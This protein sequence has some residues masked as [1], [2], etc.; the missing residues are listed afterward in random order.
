M[1]SGF[2][3]DGKFYIELRSRTRAVGNMREESDRR[4]RDL[5]EQYGGNFLLGFSGGLDSQSVLHSFITQGIPLE[6]AFLHCPGHN[7]HELEQVR[8]L[9]GKYGIKTGVVIIDPEAAK[10]E[11]M[12]LSEELDV[13]T[14]NNILQMLFL[15]RLPAD[16]NFIQMVHDPF[17]YVY[18]NYEKFSYIQGYYLPEI[19]R[20]RAFASLARSGA[21]IF[22]GNTEEF[23]LSIIGDPIFRAALASAKYFDGNGLGHPQKYLRTVDRWDYYIK[24]LIYGRYWGR[25]LTYFPKWAGNE[26]LDF[27]N[28][29]H[30]FRQR[31]V[32]IPYGEL[33]AFL[34]KPGGETRRFYE[35]VK[36]LAELRANSKKDHS[37]QDPLA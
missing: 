3:E 31:A 6:T 11:I 25:E 37:E 4:A 29:N 24:P 27:L 9:D 15:S 10:D 1:N 30:K 16:K 18:E 34:R 23:L 33:M 13:P 36:T 19:T 21:N 2:D 35:N 8:F 26:T 20:G 22:Y 7:D 5:V 17:V 12:A 28:T 14:R 32:E